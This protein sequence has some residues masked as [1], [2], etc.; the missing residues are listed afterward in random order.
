MTPVTVKINELT[1]ILQF[2]TALMIH[3]PSVIGYI[4][5]RWTVVGSLY[6]ESESLDE[7]PRR[8]DHIISHHEIAKPPL[9]QESQA[10]V[11]TLNW[12]CAE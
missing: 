5:R 7:F 10:K 1:T 3:G 4:W 8:I 6:A 12:R 11:T 9:S 2:L